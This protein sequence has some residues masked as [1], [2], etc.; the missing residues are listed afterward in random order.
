V[1]APLDDQGTTLSLSAVRSTKLV[2]SAKLELRVGFPPNHCW[3][4][5][6]SAAATS[7]AILVPVLA[8]A[9]F[10]VWKGAV[11]YAGRQPRDQSKTGDGVDYT[12][13]GG[14]FQGSGRQVSSRRDRYA[15]QR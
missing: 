14:A 7:L 6:M 9:G 5:T 10:G 4:R 11:H 1:E 15:T 3:A 8:I 2:H 12:V 13:H